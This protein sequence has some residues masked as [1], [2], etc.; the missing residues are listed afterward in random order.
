[1]ADGGNESSVRLHGET[2]QRLKEIQEEG[3]TLKE[4]MNKILPDDEEVDIIAGSNTD[5]VAVPIPS[6]V[7]ER[8]N[9]MAGQN[10][11]ANDV[12]AHLIEEYENE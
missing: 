1:M 10:V 5:P 6:E 3:E 8:V 4:A 9:E 2:Y 11:S 7:S 12:V